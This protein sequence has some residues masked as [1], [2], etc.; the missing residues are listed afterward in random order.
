MSVENECMQTLLCAQQIKSEFTSDVE[1]TLHGHLSLVVDCLRCKRCDGTIPEAN[2]TE[3]LVVDGKTVWVCKNP[4][5]YVWLKFEGA[6]M[7]MIRWKCVVSMKDR[8]TSEELRKL[9][10][11]KV[12][13]SGRIF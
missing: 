3:N 10:G 12:I 2:I 5:F 13:R 1:K 7:K 11:L 8:R 4:L 9:V 6:E